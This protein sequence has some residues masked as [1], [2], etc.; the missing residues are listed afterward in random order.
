[1]RLLGA[2]RWIKLGFFV[3]Q[4]SELAKLS[5]TIYLSAWF[6]NAE[7][8]RFISFLLLLIMIVGLVMIEPDMGTSAILV[9]I[10][11][12][13]Y[14]ATGAPLIHFL[15]FVPVVIV[16]FGLL[17]IVS[18]YRFERILSFINPHEDLLG[19]SYQIH[20]AL[21]AIG[22]GGW[23]GVGIGKSR[24][25]Y[26]YLPEANT[27]SIFAI[28]AE[29]TGFIGS[30]MI[31]MAFVFLMSRGFRIAK[32]SPDAFG[33][34]LAMGI[35]GW[36]GIQSALNLAAMVAFVPLTGIPLPLVSYGGSSLIITLAAIGI[37]LNISKQI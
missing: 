20:Q 6:S 35:T 25:K 14:F 13:I 18:P 3:L 37:L 34:Y 9:G 24:Q 5:L 36:I 16:G 17:A 33:R 30:C 26:D 11:L 4:P 1:M 19:S 32:K 7:K 23:F 2:H 22:S 8:N 31:V 12:I 10:S 27:D 28:M 21:L 29:E 15:L